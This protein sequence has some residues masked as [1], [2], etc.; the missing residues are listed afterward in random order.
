MFP[1]C[2]KA[3]VQESS[4]RAAVQYTFSIV[5][6]YFISVISIKIVKHFITPSLT[7][8]THIIMHSECTSWCKML[9]VLHVWDDRIYSWVCKMLVTVRNTVWKSIPESEK[10]L[11][12][13]YRQEMVS[14]LKN[15]VKCHSNSLWRLK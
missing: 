1:P 7:A 12:D 9:T 6:P 11:H 2:L 5:I 14:N 3:R 10:Q 4:Q 15:V 13:K 8:F